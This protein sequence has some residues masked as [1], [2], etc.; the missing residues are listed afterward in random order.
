LKNMPE[1][2]PRLPPGQEHVEDVCQ[3]KALWKAQVTKFGQASEETKMLLNQ[4]KAAVDARESNADK[5]RRLAEAIHDVVKKLRSGDV[6]LER[7]V[8]NKQMLSDLHDQ[9]EE[10]QAK[11]DK[12]VKSNKEMSHKLQEMKSGD[13]RTQ[14]QLLCEMNSDGDSDQELDAPIDPTKENHQVWEVKKAS[15]KRWRRVL[16]WPRNECDQA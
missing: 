1:P 5:A 12:F 7:H 4:W 9:K 10:M 11:L 3:I 2:V 8:R 13:P 15:R 16:P 6:T 14:A